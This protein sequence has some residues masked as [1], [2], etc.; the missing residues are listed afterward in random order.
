MSNYK[1][2]NSDGI[3]FDTNSRGIGIPTVDDIANAP[4]SSVPAGSILY[5]IAQK[6]DLLF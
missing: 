5:A 3:V 6:K 1:F 2:K 4:T